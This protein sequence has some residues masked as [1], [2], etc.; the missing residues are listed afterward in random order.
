MLNFCH[1]WKLFDIINRIRLALAIIIHGELTNGTITHLESAR[2]ELEFLQTHWNDLG[3]D[4]IKKLV[5]ADETKAQTGILHHLKHVLQANIWQQIYAQM[6]ESEKM[7]LQEQAR[8]RVG[9]LVGKN[10]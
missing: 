1:N 7:Y 2:V 8:E 9:R 3:K 6:R 5:L 4:E 10:D